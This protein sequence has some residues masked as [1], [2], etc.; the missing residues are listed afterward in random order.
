MNHLIGLSRPFSTPTYLRERQPVIDHKL[1][2]RL[3]ELL[4]RFDLTKL[5]VV[6]HLGLGVGVGLELGLG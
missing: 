1:L 4:S 3:T 2:Y 6:R 5:R